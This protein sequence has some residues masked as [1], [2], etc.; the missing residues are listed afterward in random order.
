M[1]QREKQA[2]V[3]AG[4]LLSGLCLGALLI[5]TVGCPGLLPP[6]GEPN[7]PRGNSGL[8]GKY[9][10]S[11]RCKDCH[12]L[13]HSDWAETLH[14]GALD[15]LEEIGQGTNAACLGCHTVGYGE[16]GGFV[17]RA[18]TNDLAGVGCETCH[19][20]ARDHVENVADESLR[21]T[22]DL[23]SSLCGRCHTSEHH[24]TYEEWQEAAG[25]ASVNEE[26]AAGMVAGT[27]FTTS[28]G[29]CHSGDVFYRAVLEEEEVANDDFVGMDVDELTPISCVMCHS[30]HKRTGNAVEP[31]EGR[32]FQLRYPEVA[33]PAPVNT[34]EAA[35]DATRF[36]LCGQCH[37]SRGRTWQSTERA[38][39]H[40]VQANVYTGEMPTP[41]GEALVLSR[42]SVHSFA[43]EQCA[44]C[45]MFRQDFQS[46]VAPAIAGHDFEV[47]YQSCSA[48]GCH[49]SQA[50]AEAV[51]ATLQAEIQARLDDIE[52]RLGDPA[53]WEYSAQGGP[54]DQ[55][56]I[57]DEIKKVR[58]LYYYA[59]NDGSLGVHNPAYVRDMLEEADAILTSIGR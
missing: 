27:S 56:A 22:V 12:A 5:F 3:H 20:A 44:T 42:V 47:N 17:D 21:P 1:S 7:E 19:G 45:H 43:P 33:N 37:H 6:G 58:F 38:P 23:S 30:P 51:R 49:P 50:Q 10:G 18:T 59:A 26:I 35:T 32:D 13:K 25:H 41:D 29:V 52:E 40:S 55:D 28:C 36:N 46:E 4:A 24:P 48:T 34:V 57:P 14:E 15:T 16:A 54:E 8:T 53:D 9:V 31:G 11:T 39:H 2:F